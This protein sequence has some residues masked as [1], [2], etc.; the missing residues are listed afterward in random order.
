MLKITMTCLCQYTTFMH[1][2]YVKIP[3]GYLSF[4]VS[5]TSSTYSW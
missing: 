2:Q 1:E 5:L 4:V 3:T